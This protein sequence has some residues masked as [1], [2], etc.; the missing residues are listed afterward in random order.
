MRSG[1]LRDVA[2]TARKPMA[3]EDERAR[4][5]GAGRALSAR[6][7]RRVRRAGAPLSAVDLLARACATSATTPTP[8]T[9]RSARSCKRSSSSTSCATR[10]VSKAGSIAWRRTCRST[11]CAI[12]SRTRRS[13]TT[14][15]RRR[16]ASRS[17]KRSR[18]AACARRWRELP[19]QQRLVVELRIY[20]ELPFAQVAEIAECS[21]DS[22]KVSFH[23]ALKKL[24]V[25]MNEENEQ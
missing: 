11:S 22:A 9:W 18:S 5:P 12:A 6:R 7:S 19:P 15:R 3:D 24:R 25:I 23:H 4:R 2:A 8:R 17:S 14:R 1:V 16:R 20:E 13:A 21:E 10:L